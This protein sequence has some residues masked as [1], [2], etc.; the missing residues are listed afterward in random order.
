MKTALIIVDPQIDFCSKTGAL[1]VPYAG[2]V[3]LE[4]NALREACEFDLCFISKDSHPPDHISFVDNNPGAEL[5]KEIEINGVKQM[6]WPRHCVR[7][8]VGSCITPYLHT[9]KS[10]IIIK[11]GCL[12]HTDSYSAFGSEDGTEKTQLLKLLR[13]ANITH[14]VVV[15]LAFDYCVCFT[16]KDSAK[17]GFQTSV[18]SS[19]TAATSS[20]GFTRA[21]LDMESCGINI[22]KNIKEYQLITK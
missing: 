7:G 11:K 22:F 17:Y 21:K 4:I 9:L 15:G 6:M 14:V 19:A 1:F 5:Y 16:A 8:S 13:D 10:D 3:I 2:E 12:K 20:E 18:I